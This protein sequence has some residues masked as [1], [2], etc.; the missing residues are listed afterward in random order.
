MI[1]IAGIAAVCLLLT[2]LLRKENPT[3]ALLVTVAGAGLLFYTVSKL[4]GSAF[5]ILGDLKTAA[6]DT[7]AYIDLMFKILGISI[8]TQV[9]CD[10]CRDNGASAISFSNG[11]SSQNSGTVPTAT[12]ISNGD[13]NCD[14]TCKM[15]RFVLTFLLLLALPGCALPPSRRSP[16]TVIAR[17]CPGMTCRRSKS[18]GTTQTACWSSWDWMILTLRR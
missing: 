1:Q 7:G 9:V 8:V 16:A 10:V 2:V 4:A 5:G 15:K 14:G 18:W 3:F 13:R 6:G 12:A 11:D 17:R